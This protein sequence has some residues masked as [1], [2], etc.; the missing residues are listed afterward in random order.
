MAKHY[1]NTSTSASLPLNSDNKI[2]MNYVDDNVVPIFMVVN[3]DFKAFGSLYT[4]DTNTTIIIC[5]IE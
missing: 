5:Y 1:A 4:S 2:K 3:A